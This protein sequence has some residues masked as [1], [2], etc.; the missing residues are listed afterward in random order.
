[1]F[2]AIPTPLRAHRAP[3]PVPADEPIPEPF[4]TPHHPAHQPA[5]TPATEEPIPDHK[6]S[7]H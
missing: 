5:H 1:M 3:D 7:L 2:D 6:P 4:D